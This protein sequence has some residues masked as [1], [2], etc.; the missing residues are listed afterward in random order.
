M[1]KAKHKALN[2]TDRKVDPG[3][4]QQ[5]RYSHERHRRYKLVLTRWRKHFRDNRQHGPRE[6]ELGTQL[7]NL[8]G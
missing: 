8:Y 7:A 3:S 1:Q 5:F 2:S 6:K 4:P